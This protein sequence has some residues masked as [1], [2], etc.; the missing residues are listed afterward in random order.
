MP[1]SSDL[2][3]IHRM[4]RNLMLQFKTHE[5]IF[6]CLSQLKVGIYHEEIQKLL[7]WNYVD[8]SPIE[9][10]L[11]QALSLPFSVVHSDGLMVN[12]APIKFD[13][14]D[15]V[16]PMNVKRALLC[17]PG[18]EDQVRKKEDKYIL[19]SGHLS[20]E[21]ADLQCPSSTR[22]TAKSAPCSIDSRPELRPVS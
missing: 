12:E 18:G 8:E 19:S 17:L 1:G 6:M 2:H 15:T 10:E 9:P 16:W 4:V 13:Q 3:T 22:L 20:S 7:S 21:M 5:E 11:L 14:R